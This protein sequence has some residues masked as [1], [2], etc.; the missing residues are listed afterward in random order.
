MVRSISAFA[1]SNGGKIFI[2]IEGEKDGS[3]NTGNIRV[4]SSDFRIELDIEEFAKLT[5]LTA[6]RKLWPTQSV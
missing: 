1:N 2:G 5:C 3:G 6:V 4:R